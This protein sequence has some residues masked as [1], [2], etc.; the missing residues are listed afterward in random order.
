MSPLQIPAG[1][2]HISFWYRGG[3]GTWGI[4][5][6]KVLWGKSSNPAEMEV[7]GEYMDF[8]KNE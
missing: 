8:V 3:W 4:E 6:M 7:L 1:D 2:N 5:S